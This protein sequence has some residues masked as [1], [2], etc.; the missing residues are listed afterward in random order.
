MRRSFA[1]AIVLAMFVTACGSTA[2]PAAPTPTTPGGQPTPAFS[3]TS[4]ICAGQATFAA[5]APSPSFL[6]DQ[7]LVNKMPTEIDGN[8]TEDRQ[9]V[10]FVQS[11]CYLGIGTMDQVAAVLSQAGVDPR[12]LSVGGFSAT[13]DDESV[14]VFAFRTP[15]NDANRIVQAFPALAAAFGNDPGNGNLQPGT[16]GGKSIS[17]TANDDGTKDVAFAS[18]DTLWSASELTDPIAEVLFA[19]L[20]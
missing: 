18:G 19:A 8:P 13:I 14:E 5:N 16:F 7:D 2:S 12:S 3:G 10:S 17:F 6:P 11:F 15:S 20:P 1:S 4:N 9:A